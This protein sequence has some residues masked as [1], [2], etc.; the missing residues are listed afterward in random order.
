MSDSS[1]RSVSP[2]HVQYLH[3]MGVEASASVSIVK[4]GALWG[5]IACHNAS[6]SYL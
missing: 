1:L 3:N 6:L 5:L 2:I 4:D